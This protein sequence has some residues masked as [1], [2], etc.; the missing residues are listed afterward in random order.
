MEFIYKNDDNER[1]ILNF[2]IGEAPSEAKI[3][4]IKFCR[5]LEAEFAGKTFCLKG[6]GWPGQ[7]S[8]RK[9]QMTNNN[10][11][12]GKRTK[13]TWGDAKKAIPNYKGEECES[14]KEV[15]NLAQKDKKE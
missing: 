1:I 11:N 5:D 6:G 7:D 15:S 10:I 12:A 3:E 2:P 9:N 4:G 14:W 13:S 8:L